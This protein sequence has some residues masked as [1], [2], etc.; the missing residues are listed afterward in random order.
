MSKK[1][2]FDCVEMKNEIQAR[3]AREYRGLTADEIRNR[4][5]SKLSTSGEPIA[6][7]WRALSAPSIKARS[8]KKRRS[9]QAVAK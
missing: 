7:L 1:K 6:R 3:L 4:I 5:Q 9:R 2:S 8:A